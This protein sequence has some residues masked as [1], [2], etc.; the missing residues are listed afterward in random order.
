MVVSPDLRQTVLVLADALDLV[1]IDDVAHG[2]RVACMA[3]QVGT[4]A[5]LDP[6]ALD[7]IMFAGLFH[8]CGVSST[9][10][11]RDLT[12]GL[13]W[14]GDQ[15]HC[16]RGEALAATFPPLAHLAP[17]VRW[18]HT[19]VAHHPAIDAPQDVLHAANLVYMVDRVDALIAG[20]RDHDTL[21]ATG[22]I[23]SII[24]E[25]RGTRFLA[26]WVDAFLEASSR[27]AFWLTLEPH[28]LGPWLGQWLRQG[29][30]RALSMDDLRPLAS[31]LARIVDAKSPY[32]A[33][34]SHRVG[35][36]AVALADAAGIGRER[37]LLIEV[38]ALLHDLGKLRVPDRIL[39]KPGP[40]A[41]AERVRITR[42]AFDTWQILSR[43]DGFG[44]IAAWA[45]HHHE[46]VRGGG[47]PFG[48]DG[49]RLSPE[50]RLIAVADVFQALRQ[51]RPYRTRMPLE[52]A[53]SEIDQMVAA[54]HLDPDLSALLHR[55]LPLC[56]AV[57]TGTDA[58]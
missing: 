17:V 35:A 43:I 8:D 50:A 45:A 3:Y 5:G 2:K 38:A 25:N 21:L 32:T 37:R 44:D 33:D 39:E 20:V 46:W 52:H 10:E 7:D 51:Q 18:H 4:L 30:P 19:H 28:A 23:R 58:A 9:R 48:L 26:R 42:H 27:E 13:D 12:A 16:I 15:A 31:V 47:Y 56:E 14:E 29:P 24:A 40:L 1:G 6:P 22:G 11:H 41:V 49:D 54:G 55:D 57:A 34:H 36:V 53:M